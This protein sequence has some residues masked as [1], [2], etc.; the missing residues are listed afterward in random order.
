LVFDLKNKKLKNSLS[1]VL[2]IWIRGFLMN[3]LQEVKEFYNSYPYPLQKIESI[4]DL[5]YKK[6]KTTMKN[7]LYCA[8]LAQEDLKNIKILDA[9]CG[10]GEKALY[11]SYYKAKVDAFDI[12]KNSIKIAKKN[13][14]K[15]KLKVNYF[16]DSFE[17]FSCS[18][19]Y[20][21]IIAIGSLHHT[22]EPKKNFLKLSKFLKPKGVIVIGLYSFYGRISCQ[23]ARFIL[24]HIFKDRKKA[25]AFL[26]KILKL[27]TT[28]AKM[29]IA[30]RY[31]SPFEL[32]HTISE[33]L[34][35]IKEAK[36]IPFRIVPK[37]GFTKLDIIKLELRLLLA[38]RSFFFISAKK[39]D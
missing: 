20:D 35:W 29:L 22:S 6:H 1:K 3:I 30:D 4:K 19:K 10:T 9:G 15:L 18:K 34:N 36:L 11:F 31:L 2:N 33:V 23:I 21:L 27:K 38:Q 12:S 24:K 39:Q 16:V 8:D 26:I 37:A 32:N 28:T 5:F 25:F 7:I 14:K 17:N 13:A